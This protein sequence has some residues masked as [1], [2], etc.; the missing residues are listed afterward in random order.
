MSMKLIVKEVAQREG[1]RNPVELSQ[2][3]G[4]AYGSCH[5]LWKGTATMI[6]VE[7]IERLCTAMRVWP[8]QLFDYQPEPEKLPSES[9]AKETKGEKKREHKR[10]GK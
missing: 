6:S 4:I 5:R 8:S 3:T 9:S 7:T 2:K 1:I 10:K